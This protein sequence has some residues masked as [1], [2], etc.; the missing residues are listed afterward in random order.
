M[1]SSNQYM[2]DKLKCKNTKDDVKHI[3]RQD[4]KMIPQMF[5]IFVIGGAITSW[6][7][8][9]E[10]LRELWEAIGWMAVVT[11]IAYISLRSVILSTVLPARQ[12]VRDHLKRMDKS[13]A[14]ETPHERKCR[15]EVEQW[16]IN[17][18]KKKG[19]SLSYIPPSIRR[20]IK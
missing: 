4:A 17:D 8:P 5:W 14:N 2:L 3:L 11:F 13:Q 16:W 1:K 12:E 7:A 18:W 20:K 10:D 6:L 15:E 9:A 19:Y